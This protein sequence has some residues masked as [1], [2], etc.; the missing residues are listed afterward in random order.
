MANHNEPG[1]TVA[2]RFGNVNTTITQDFPNFAVPV[3]VEGIGLVA[4]GPEELALTGAL[5]AGNLVLRPFIRGGKRVW[6]VFTKAGKEVAGP[7]L[8]A[9]VDEINKLKKA[10]KPAPLSTQPKFWTKSKTFNGNKVFQRDDLINLNLVDS[11]GR[12]NLQRMQKGVAPIGPDGQSINLH[13][14]IQTQDGAI[15]E[16]TQTFHQ[17][18]YGALHINPNTIPSGIDRDAF[19]AW[20]RQYWIARAKELGGLP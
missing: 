12:T 15:A 2:K 13:H 17:Q 4:A 5:K 8:N 9:L 11:R 3:I 18:N 14:M 16:V 20:K 1:A 19:D 6:K 7:Q 10:R